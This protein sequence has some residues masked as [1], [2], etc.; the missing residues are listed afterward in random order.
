MGGPVELWYI[1]HVSC[2][3]LCMTVRNRT[4][5]LHCI[6]YI[7]SYVCNDLLHSVTSSAQPRCVCSVAPL[8]IL[9]WVSGSDQQQRWRP[10]KL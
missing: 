9:G 6:G 10:P 2:C 1:V 3:D 4:L 8:V 7:M 5:P